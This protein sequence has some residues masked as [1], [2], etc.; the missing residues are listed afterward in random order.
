MTDKEILDFF[1]L[2]LLNTIFY[3]SA[4]ILNLID[5]MVFGCENTIIEED[6][7]HFILDVK[8]TSYNKKTFNR[9]Y[10][11]HLANSQK[12]AEFKKIVKIEQIK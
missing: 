5:R 4:M 9:Q 3:K 12:H 10:V 7:K 8:N 6:D 11:F 2:G 1:K